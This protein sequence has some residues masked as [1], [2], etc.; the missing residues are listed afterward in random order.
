M[1]LARAADPGDTRPMTSDPR[2]RRETL[3][4][5]ALLVCAYLPQLGALTGAARPEERFNMSVSA[6]MHRLGEWATPTL[7]GAPWFYKPPL[8]YWLERVAYVV[9]GPSAFTA[10]LPAAL[11]AIALALLTGLIAS[12]LGANR[13]LATLLTGGSVGL[14]LN[15]RMAITDSL[16]ALGLAG[17]FALI[18]EAHQRDDSRWLI[19]AGAPLGVALL[20]K[21]PVAGVIVLL[22][23]GLFTLLRTPRPR[24]DPLLRPYAIVLAALVALAVAAP[25]YGLMYARHGQRFIDFFFVQM[26]V[27]R[28]RT[29]WRVESLAVLWGGLLLTVTPWLPLAVAGVA[30]ARKH[31]REPRFLFALSW[32]F[33][34]M[35]TFSIPAQKFVHYSLPAAP[36]FA[37]LIAM[38]PERQSQRVA[39][40]V[41]AG[42][43]GVAALIGVLAARVLP[44]LPALLTAAAAGLGVFAAVKHRPTLIAGAGLAVIALALGWLA[45]SAGFSPWPSS[46][47][48]ERPLYAWREPPGVLEFASG[49]DARWLSERAQ[50]DEALQSGGLVWMHERDYPGAPWAIIA[51]TP[52]LRSDVTPDALIAAFRQG[53]LA[54]LIG[55]VVLVGR[56]D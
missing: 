35:V 47:V 33:A 36:A 30:H 14:F 21:G 27:D 50:L 40:A 23:A 26:N 22:F 7:D 4:L 51:E 34:V 16:L 39:D 29:P 53:S 46:P 10:R 28:F 6:E 1:R 43:F 25:W 55:R 38:L 49:R 9:G 8:L 42:I 31:W 15:G 45:P 48:P 41:M 2:A 32:A 20:A 11:A 54:P 3:A 37:L 13:A 24:P 17:T 19:A 52:A 5:L 56:P 18:W 12:R 44:A